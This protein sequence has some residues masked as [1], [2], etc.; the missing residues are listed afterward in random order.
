[1]AL[2]LRLPESPPPEKVVTLGGNCWDSMDVPSNRRHSATVSASNR[3][4]SDRFSMVLSSKELFPIPAVHV[5][6]TWAEGPTLE[7]SSSA[8]E[9]GHTADSQGLDMT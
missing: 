1:M 2:G 8:L 7:A 5:Y 3:A 9:A 6:S 4:V